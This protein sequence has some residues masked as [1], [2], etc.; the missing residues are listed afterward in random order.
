MF[1][2]APGE[3]FALDMLERYHDISTGGVEVSVIREVSHISGP[4]VS[5]MLNTLEK[6]D[7]IKRVMSEEDRRKILV[8]L[9]PKGREILAASKKIFLDTVDRIYDN[10]GEEDTRKFIE[11]LKRFQDIFYDTVPC[12]K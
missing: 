12:E 8:C 2:M 7:Y 10:F 11:L 1:G 5:Q 4:A 3:F 9:T 6:K